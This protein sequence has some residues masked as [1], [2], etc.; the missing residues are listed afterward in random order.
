MPRVKGVGR[1]R[2]AKSEPK[3]PKEPKLDESVTTVEGGSESEEEGEDWVTELLYGI[4]D[5]AVD[6]QRRLNWRFMKYAATAAACAEAL[7]LDLDCWCPLREAAYQQALAE[8]KSCIDGRYDT[9][10]GYMSKKYRC[11]SCGR[12][13]ALCECCVECAC[14]EYRGKWS[15]QSQLGCTCPPKRPSRDWEAFSWVVK[16][17]C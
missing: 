7:R 1:K 13:V 11:G 12:S 3:E 5:S 8:M 10:Y 17:T 15:W 6:E 9:T 2:K 16:E 4:I 14:E